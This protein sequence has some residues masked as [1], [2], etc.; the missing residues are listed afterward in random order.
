MKYNKYLNK[1]FLLFVAS[2]LCVHLTHA[3]KSKQDRKEE[4]MAI[5]ESLVQSKNFVFVA[6][7]AL[8]STGRNINLTTTYAVRLSSDTVVSDL[9]YF[10]RAFV[11]PMNPSEGGIHFT[12]TKFTY[13]TKEKKK[14]G[15]EIT[16]LPTDTRDVR[17]MFLTVSQQGY[18]TLQ[19][20]SNNR[21]SISFNGYIT[22]RS[23]AR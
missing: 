12:S 10:G 7:N 2:L 8:P 22:S 21:Q 14:G 3:Q 19:V 16:I 4:K 11:A 5:I 13:T 23:K 9:P 15:W 18:A 1:F 17:Q 20:L 6:Q